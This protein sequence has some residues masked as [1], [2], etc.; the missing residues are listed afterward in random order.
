[1][2]QSRDPRAILGLAAGASATEVKATHRFLVKVLH[3]DRFHQA[4]DLARPALEILKRVNA[5]SRDAASVPA[6]APTSRGP[7]S[8]EIL[9]LT[10]KATPDKIERAALFWRAALAQE[11]FNDKDDKERA[12]AMLARIEIAY[13]TI[14]PLQEP[15]KAKAAPASNVPADIVVFLGNWGLHNPDSPRLWSS[16]RRMTRDQA[17][18][19]GLRPCRTCRA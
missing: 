9:W 18:A 1:V 10:P 14:R 6:S 15:R 8:F 12:S 4:P 16:S 19:D 3:P 13:R 7:T 2:S 5:A 17:I 11:R